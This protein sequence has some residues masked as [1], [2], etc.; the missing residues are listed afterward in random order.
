MLI[1]QG[2]QDILINN[3]KGKVWNMV[4]GFIDTLCVIYFI[5]SGVCIKF[6]FVP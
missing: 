5:Y 4:C 2:F 6:C 3:K 1:W